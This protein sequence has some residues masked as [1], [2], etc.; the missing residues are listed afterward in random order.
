MTNMKCRDS[1]AGRGYVFGGTQYGSY[2]FCGAT[3][4]KIGS[5][6]NC[7]MGCSG[8]GNEIC[9]GA[10]ANSVSLSG[11]EPTVPPAPSNGNQCNV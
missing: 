7:D 9:G 2:C 11:A 10:W 3:Y 5:A 6:T 8:N 4:G 1:C